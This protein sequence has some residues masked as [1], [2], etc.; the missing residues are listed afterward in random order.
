MPQTDRIAPSLYRISYFW[1]AVVTALFGFVYNASSADIDIQQLVEQ[2]NSSKRSER[3][4]AEEKL[5][6]AELNVLPE[7]TTLAEQK[8]EHRFQLLK[9]IEKIRKRAAD[10]TLRGQTVFFDQERFTADERVK[11]VL[12]QT[13]IDLRLPS[14]VLK[15]PTTM[16]SGQYPF[17]QVVDELSKELNY[18]WQWNQASIYFVSS[19]SKEDVSRE[20][21]DCFRVQVSQSEK[22]QNLRRQFSRGLMRLNFQFDLEPTVRPFLLNFAANDFQ[23]TSTTDEGD[24]IGKPFSPG[25]KL[26]LPAGKSPRFKM[27]L[28]FM[29]RDLPEDA[30]LSVNGKIELICS[31]RPREIRASLLNKKSIQPELKIVET[32]EKA[33]KIL[34]T[35]DI[36][37]PEELAEFDSHRLSLLHQDAWL[38]SSDGTRSKPEQVQILSH[39]GSRHRVE[40]SF[41]SDHAMHTGTFVYLFPDH[42]VLFP[43]SF[44]VIL[45]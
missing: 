34:M 22:R 35:V 9:L 37:L 21:V 28:D 42:V 36:Q 11:Q 23:L 31:A 14:N 44:K 10:Q 7:L 6:N 19:Q 17:W 38:E 2:L 27:S 5:L 18:D 25:S 40:F 12:K 32:S 4:R 15:Q 24:W 3:I 33:N 13:G 39:T 41:S 16:E 29:A 45:E 43:V 1:M 30:D 8:R 20:Y 26:E